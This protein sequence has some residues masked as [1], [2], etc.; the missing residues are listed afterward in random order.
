MYNIQLAILA[1]FT[2]SVLCRPSTARIFQLSK[3]KYVI[4]QLTIPLSPGNHSSVLCLYKSNCLMYHRW[5]YYTIFVI[6]LFLV[7]FT[8]HLQPSPHVSG[9]PSFLG[10]NYIWIIFSAEQPL[11]VHPIHLSYMHYFCALQQQCTPFF[12]MSLWLI[13]RTYN[14]KWHPWVIW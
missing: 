8:N 10:V 6:L 5:I 9:F 2:C 14:W 12:R 3:Q 4:K 1:I 11:C 7:Y 13:L